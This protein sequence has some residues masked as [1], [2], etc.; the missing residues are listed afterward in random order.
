MAALDFPNS[1]SD[2]QVYT[3]N[4]KTW[5][6][7]AANTC[8]NNNTSPASVAS[9]INATDDNSTNTSFYPVCVGAAGNSQTPKI[10]TTTL[11]YNPYTQVLS[12][13]GTIRATNDVVAFY[14]DNRLKNFLGVI[15]NPLE[16]VL[17][18][19]GYFFT[20]NELAKELG[21]NDESVQVGVSAQEVQAVLPEVVVPAPVGE[22]YLTV[23]Y[24]KLVPLLIEAIKEQQKQIDEL[25]TMVGLKNG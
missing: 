14:S 17:S 25:K 6:Y 3:A 22:D 23:K 1:P 16:R 15:S 12:F 7:S 20:P 18:L 9:S 5:V 8:W 21:Y 2:G 19:N 4:G 24:D 10:S 13:T 11:S